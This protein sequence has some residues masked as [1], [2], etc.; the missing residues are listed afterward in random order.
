[1]SELLIRLIGGVI[2]T[3]G[4]VIVFGVKLKHMPVSVLCGIVGTVVYLL[5]TECGFHEFV[6]NTIAAFVVTIYSEIAARILRSPA[7][8]FQMPGVI[9]LVPGKN[10]YYTMSSLIASDFAA[11]GNYAVITLQVSAGIADGLICGTVLF[12]FLKL[13]SGSERGL[14]KTKKADNQIK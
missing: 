12:G 6:S 3:L 7:L 4:F 11:A 13:M 8:V 9:V 10:L 1:M 14:F 2:G 5:C